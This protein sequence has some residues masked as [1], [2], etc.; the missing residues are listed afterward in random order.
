[1]GTIDVTLDRYCSAKAAT[2]RDG[3]YLKLLPDEW[4]RR[5]HRVP[6]PQLAPLLDSQPLAE[7]VAAAMLQWPCCECC[8]R[9]FKPKRRERLYQRCDRIEDGFEDGFRAV[10]TLMPFCSDWCVRAT[11]YANPM[12]LRGAERLTIHEYYYSKS[13]SS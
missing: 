1:M 6:H 8:R 5:V 9:Y 7:K 12:R 10:I 3:L 13:S 11:Y 2:T 4:Y